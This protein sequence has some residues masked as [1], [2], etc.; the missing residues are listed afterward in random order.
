MKSDHKINKIC[1]F[2]N[3]KNEKSLIKSTFFTKFVYYFCVC[4]FND[5]Y[6][7]IQISTNLKFVYDL[8]E[9]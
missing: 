5:F 4:I 8:F 3:K 2:T 7:G 6:V 1:T 9:T